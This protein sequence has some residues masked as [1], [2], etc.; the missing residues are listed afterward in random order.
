MWKTLSLTNKIFSALFRVTLIFIITIINISCQKRDQRSWWRGDSKAVVFEHPATL[1]L[2]SF[3]VDSLDKVIEPL[4]ISAAGKHLIALEANAAP[5]LHL[6]QTEPQLKHLTSFGKLGRGPFEYEGP[7][8]LSANCTGPDCTLFVYDIFLLRSFA[9]KI[10]EPDSEPVPISDSPAMF[11]SGNGAVTDMSALDDTTFV[12]IGLFNKGRLQF[13]NKSGEPTVLSGQVPQDGSK[14][15]ATILSQAFMGELAINPVTKE[16]AVAN[17]YSDKIEIYNQNGNQKVLLSGPD[18]F[19]PVYKIVDTGGSFPTMSSD[20]T[21]RFGY[22]SICWTQSG[23]LFALYSGK[24]RKEL[25][26][27]GSGKF[28]TEFDNSGKITKVFELPFYASD[29]AC[30]DSGKLFFTVKTKASS[31]L[32]SRFL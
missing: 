11:K 1:E 28:L 31:Y 27:S 5:F 30:G 13:F 8:T 15:P 29:I 19:N 24:M 18:H 22:I 2:S 25:E 23:S 4:R 21:M 12:S 6:Y 9:Y 17:L 10:K 16:I 3:T 26:I 14:S 7:Y 32:Y 20:K